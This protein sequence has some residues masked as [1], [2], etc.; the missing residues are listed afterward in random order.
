[1]RILGENKSGI[2]DLYL[3]LRA[4]LVLPSKAEGPVKV[5]VGCDDELSVR[6]VVV[7]CYI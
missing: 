1:M 2:R 3:Q 4:D 5:S 6:L 7:I